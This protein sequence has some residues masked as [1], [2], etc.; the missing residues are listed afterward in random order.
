MTEPVTARSSARPCTRIAEPR[1]AP[2][3]RPAETPRPGARRRAPSAALFRACGAAGRHRLTHADVLDAGGHE[4]RAQL[5]PVALARI[6]GDDRVDAGGGLAGIDG[7]VA[8]HRL[9]VD[10]D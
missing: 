2:L 6:A 5:L 3:P 8:R 1:C 7:V 9:A 10:G 4:R